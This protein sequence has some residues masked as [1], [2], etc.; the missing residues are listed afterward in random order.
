M[1]P[2]ALLDLNSLNVAD[3]ERLKREIEIDDLEVELMNY[4]KNVDYCDEVLR[5]R[6]RDH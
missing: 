2:Y 1:N 6:N 5:R 3:I 4:I